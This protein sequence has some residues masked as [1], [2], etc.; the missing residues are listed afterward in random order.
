M[1]IFDSDAE[2]AEKAEDDLLWKGRKQYERR[3]KAVN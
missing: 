2:A 3:I 1:I